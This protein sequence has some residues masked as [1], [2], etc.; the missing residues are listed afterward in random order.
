MGYSVCFAQLQQHPLYKNQPLCIKNAQMQKVALFDR[1][2]NGAVQECGG[3]LV[4]AIGVESVCGELLV[5]CGLFA[6]GVG[7]AYHFDAQLL[8][9]VGF[10][11]IFQDG[12]PESACCRVFFDS[13]QRA[14]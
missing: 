5:A 3:R 9:P 1:L 14:V 4:Q 10:G 8:E 7:N 2:R 11:G 6:E 12:R 13:D